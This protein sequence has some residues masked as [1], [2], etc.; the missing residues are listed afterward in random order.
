[1]LKKRLIGLITVRNGW[2][3]QSL[4]YRSYLPL[5]RPEYLVENLDRWGADEI[6]VHSID[7]TANKSGPD[8]DLLDRLARLGSGTPLTFGGGIRSVQDGIQLVQRGADRITVDALIRDAP[9]VVEELSGHLGAQ[10]VIASLPVAVEG[11]ELTLLDYRTQK[12]NPF[13]KHVLQAIKRGIFSEI[14]LTDWRHE[15][16]P[17]AFDEAVIDAFPCREAALIVF[18]GISNKIQMQSLLAR[19]QVVA[20]A[21]GN[22]L[23]YKEHAVQQLRKVIASESLRPSTYA[24]EY[25]LIRNV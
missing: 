2:A 21:V 23:N 12:A 18:G 5:G 11:R 8:F 25:S 13:P 14:L 7:R 4:G 22:F 9:A 6:F 17:S 16:M 15:G 20:F 24:A 3:V 1:M 19:P 10:A